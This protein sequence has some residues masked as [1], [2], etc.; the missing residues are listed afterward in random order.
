MLR[1]TLLQA[2]DAADLAR[3]EEHAAFAARLSVDPAQIRCVDLLRT[4]L[5]PGILVGSDAL[6]VG[7]SGDY[8]VLDEVPGI[9]GFIRFL[10]EV[11]ELGFP[12]FASCFGF[13]ALALALGGTV[14][15]DPSRAEVGSYLLTPTDAGRRDPLFS[16]LPTPFVAQLGHKDHVTSLPDGVENLAGSALS[17]FQA[18]KVTGKPIYATQFHPEL[19]WQDNRQRYLR[20]MA[21]Y[22]ALFGPA[23]AQERLDSHVPGPEANT[24]LAGFVRTVLS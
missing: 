11:C 24:L 18:L 7:G 3:E 1:F 9:Q 17:P 12:T 22:G 23:E 10:G 8:S 21:T 16:A 6:L 19:T 5:E 15:S 4:V 2:R 20:Y 14:V 13:Q